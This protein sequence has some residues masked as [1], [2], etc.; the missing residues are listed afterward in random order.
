MCGERQTTNKIQ[1]RVWAERSTGFTLV[2]LLVVI[3][4]IGILIGLLL[5]AVQAARE[6]ARRTTCANN[7]RQIGLALAS[8]ESTHGEFPSSWTPAIPT[9]PGSGAQLPSLPWLASGWSAQAKLL[10]FMEQAQ[11]EGFI[12]YTRSYSKQ[13]DLSIG[14]KPAPHIA[15]T[16]IPAYICPDEVRDEVR[17]DSKGEYATHYPINY[18]VNQGIWLTFDPNDTSAGRGAFRPVYGVSSGEIFDGLTNTIAF[19]EVKAYT[20]Y[21]RNLSS[22]DDLSIPASAELC[23][24]GG[25]FKLSSGHTEWV[26]GRVHQTGFTTV[27]GPNSKHHCDINDQELSVDW[28]N[29]QEGKS[30]EIR[31]F[32]AVTARSYHPGGLNVL[33]MGGSVHFVG[34]AIDLQV[35]RGLSTRSDGEVF[36]P[37]F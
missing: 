35:W 36:Q 1:H 5:P 6:A 37:P 21:F 3:A 10:P 17:L 13:G 28:T 33:M 26:D 7:L 24:L 8:F 27:F 30:A 14:G 22:S 32:A 29:Q 2:E 23:D 12:D 4:I 25:S 15:S 11:L 18:A 16:R 34:N 31:T 20:P 9:Q 19:A